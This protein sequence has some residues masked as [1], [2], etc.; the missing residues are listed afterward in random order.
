MRITFTKIP[1]GGKGAINLFLWPVNHVGPV[2]P[3]AQ[4]SSL[5]RK[6]NFPFN[7]MCSHYTVADRGG[8]PL[9]LHRGVS[10]VALLLS[11][12]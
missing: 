3:G 4:F 8:A 1:V 5:P 11:C 10:Q 9:L 12:V 6:G 7:E 2:K